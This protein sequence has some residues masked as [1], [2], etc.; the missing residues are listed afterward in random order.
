V[1]FAGCLIKVGV[2]FSKTRLASIIIS[3]IGFADSV[4]LTIEKYTNNRNMC[5]PGVGDCYTVNTSKYSEIYGI[6][7]AVI[8]IAVYLIFAAI[9]LLE[10][11]STFIKENGS[12]I[13]L[14]ISLTGTLFSIYLTYL[15][16]FVIMAICPFCVL[17]ALAMLA[18]LILT[19]VRMANN[20]KETYD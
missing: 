5:I 11:K 7:V 3:F 1:F 19:I 17:S 20:Q 8:G 4:Y 16:L 14:G 10:N 13:G 15:E 12:L 6:P 2:M 18:L 9:L